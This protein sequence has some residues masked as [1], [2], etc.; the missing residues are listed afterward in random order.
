MGQAGE[1]PALTRN[2]YSARAA[3]RHGRQAGKPT[4]ERLL[5]QSVVEC[6]PESPR[7]AGSSQRPDMVSGRKQGTMS[8][9]RRAPFRVLLATVV[10]ACRSVLTLAPAQAAAYRYWGF[11]Q[12]TGTTWAFAQKGPDQTVPKDGAVDGWR[13]A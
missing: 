11:Y 1:N 6:G 12:L 5:C 3:R 9:V 4:S 8:M 13:F 2:R 10:A 7:R